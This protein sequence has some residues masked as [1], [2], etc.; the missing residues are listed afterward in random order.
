[1]NTRSVEILKKLC[2]G[3]NYQVE[4]LAHDF[5]ISIRMI[6]YVIDDINDFFRNNKY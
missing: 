3:K 5:E 6:R 2:G 1:M 4:D